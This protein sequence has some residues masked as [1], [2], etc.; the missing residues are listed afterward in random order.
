MVMPGQAEGAWGS[1]Q[2]KK[3]SSK[4][5]HPLTPR[6]NCKQ[7]QRLQKR[8]N[9]ALSDVPVNKQ[10]TCDT[11]SAFHK[12]QLRSNGS[13]DGVGT[14]NDYCR[15]FIVHEE[16]AKDAPVA[17]ACD[18]NDPV[19]TENTAAGSEDGETSPPSSVHHLDDTDSNDQSSCMVDAEASEYRTPYTHEIFS[20][21]RRQRPRCHAH[22][23]ERLQEENEKLAHALR[24]RTK[25]TKAHSDVDSLRQQNYELA[26]KHK[27]SLQKQE[28]LLQ[29]CVTFFK[30]DIQRPPEII[31]CY[32]VFITE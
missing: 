30:T 1:T 24:R 21:R 18:P 31:E 8:V 22:L 25:R 6:K 32:F 28:E 17:T 7:A 20:E 15:S 16:A 3:P 2:H 26:C 23:S 27:E 5:N 10:N 29:V 12:T 13:T 9:T 14:E 4:P 19:C 11:I